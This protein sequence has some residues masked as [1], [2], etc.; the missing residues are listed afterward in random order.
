M[1]F[2]FA[3]L[4]PHL[5]LRWN[6]RGPRYPQEV[7]EIEGPRYG[8]KSVAEAVRVVAI[9]I[10]RASESEHARFG[11]RIARRDC[12]VTSIVEGPARWID[13]ELFRSRLI[14]GSICARPDFRFVR[15][16]PRI[17]ENL[18]IAR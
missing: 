15:G 5:L 7:S 2:Y 1:E 14:A 16:D 10:G 8:P 6:P 4:K 17:D 13:T 3:A 18:F 12:V 11:G 9:L